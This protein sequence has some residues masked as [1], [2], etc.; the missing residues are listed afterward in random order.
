LGGSHREQGMMPFG[1][2]SKVPVRSA[3]SPAEADDIHAYVIDREWAAYAQ[4]QRAA[5][6]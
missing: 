6:H 2:P 4:E 1:V 5:S 3:L